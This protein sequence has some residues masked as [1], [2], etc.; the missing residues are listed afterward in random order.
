ML[1]R[2]LSGVLGIPFAIFIIQTGGLILSLSLLI[3]SMIGLREFF[4]TVKKKG[5]NP[6]VF[7]CYLSAA[8]LFSGSYFTD[9]IHLLINF[10]IVLTCL[11]SFIYG[12][13]KFR[14]DS[15]IN[16]FLSTGA[17][18]YI[19]VGFFHVVM[20][21][22]LE[23]GSILVW[24][25]LIT[26][27]STDTF[28]YFSGHIFGKHKLIPS[29][30]PKKTVEGAIGGIVGCGILTALYGRMFL[31]DLDLRGII[32]LTIIGCIT[33][34]FSIFGDLAA[35]MIKRNCDTKDYGNLIPGHGGILD[36]FDSI[37]FTAP[38]VYYCIIIF[39]G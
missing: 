2:I 15:Y 8:M 9:N 28:A 32:L 11:I 26:A 17:A 34:V 1:K 24:L 3:I 12:V 13:L 18:I 39:L 30:S 21:R 6:P 33:S 19:I 4:S 37:L 31:V 20:I 14:N 29:V 23:N 7:I 10:V 16:S 27:W 36:R 5:H 35:S 25:A 22:Q 38:I